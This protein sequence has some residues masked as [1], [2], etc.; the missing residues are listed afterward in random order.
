[1]NNMFSDG[2]QFRD[3]LALAQAADEVGDNLPCRQAPD[4]F[5]S[6]GGDLYYIH[7][8]KRAC[9]PCPLVQQCLTYALKHN[10]IDGVWGGTTAGERKKLRRASRR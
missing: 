1:M 9:Q 2:D 5:Y 8:A 6:G 7:L 10:E 4:L 3:W